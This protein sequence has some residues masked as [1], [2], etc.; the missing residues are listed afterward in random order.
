MYNSIILVHIAV[1]K[2]IILVHITVYNILALC[3]LPFA[4]V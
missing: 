2:S 1:Y 3:T 4:V